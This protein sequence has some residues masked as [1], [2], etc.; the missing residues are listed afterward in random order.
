MESLSSG[1]LEFSVQSHKLL[2][3]YLYWWV[4]EKPDCV[5]RSLLLGS[6]NFRKD[7]RQFI[8]FIHSFVQHLL[9]GA[10]ETEVTKIIR[11]VMAVALEAAADVYFAC[12]FR[13]F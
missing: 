12:R 13:S 7:P 8:V 6:L 2:K 5:P 9:L 4:F 10:V 11:P 1:L 3:N